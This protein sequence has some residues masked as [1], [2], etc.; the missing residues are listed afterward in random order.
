MDGLIDLGQNLRGQALAGMQQVSNMETNRANYNRELRRREN[1]M[2]GEAAG[3]AVGLATQLG[4]DKLLSPG[5][6]TVASTLTPNTLNSAN[7]AITPSSLS[8]V[9]PTAAP[10]GLSGSLT[11]LNASGTGINLG[12]NATQA[13]L[14][15]ITPG[16]SSTGGAAAP[17]SL[18]SS[19]GSGTAAGSSSLG[20][21]LGSAASAVATPVGAGMLGAGLAK[22]FGGSGEVQA[23]AGGATALLALAYMY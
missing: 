6:G 14:Q 23:A 21:S 9:A 7:L 20:A 10:S 2:K 3:Q 11:G 12:A 18:A 19:V 4:V 1:R 22:M 15:A 16:L 17:T 5:G 13:G 8:S